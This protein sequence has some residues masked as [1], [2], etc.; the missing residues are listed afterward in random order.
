MSYMFLR[1]VRG[2]TILYPF[3]FIP[4]FELG[5][6]LGRFGLG[7]FELGVL[8]VFAGFSCRGILLTGKLY[9]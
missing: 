2:M 4:N 6:E 8:F 1:Q 9:I 3:H 7:Y 5:F